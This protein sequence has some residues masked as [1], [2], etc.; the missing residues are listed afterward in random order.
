MPSRESCKPQS[1]SPC[2]YVPARNYRR[3]SFENAGNPYFS[4]STFINDL[5]GARRRIGAIRLNQIPRNRFL[6]IPRRRARFSAH[7]RS[8]AGAVVGKLDEA[9][10][11]SLLS[12]FGHE[13]KQCATIL[14]RASI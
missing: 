3:A 6:V 9:P 2:R 4:G 12:F 8:P 13:R 1:T 14:R 10:R 7:A 5:Q 11:R